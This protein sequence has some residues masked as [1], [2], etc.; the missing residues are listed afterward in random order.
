MTST[1]PEILVVGAGSAGAAVAAHLAEQ[2]RSVVLVD[3][4]PPEKAGAHWINAVPPWLFDEAGIA[5]PEPPECVRPARSHTSVITDAEGHVCAHIAEDP[6]LHVDMRLLTQRLQRRAMAAGAAFEHGEV[7][8]VGL[9]EGRI[10]TVTLRSVH[11][12]RVFLPR[13]TVDASGL[14]AVI[15]RRV[16]QLAIAYPGPRDTDI[17]QAAQHQ[18]RLADLDGAKAFLEAHGAEPGSNVTYTAVAGGYSILMV[19]VDETLDHVGVLSGTIPA[20]GV[21]DGGAVVDRFVADNPWIGARLSGG[22]APIP[23]G[24]PC[25]RLSAPGVALVGNAAGHVYAMHGSGVGLGLVAARLLAD[26]VAAAPDPG[27]PTVLQR[28]GA[29]FL[30]TYGGRLAASDL[31]RRF[32]QSLSPAEVSEFMRSGL[33]NGP[34]MLAGLKQRPIKA[35]PQAL[36][37]VLRGAKANPRLIAKLGPMA[38]R[39]L[40]AEKA[41]AFY[42]ETGNGVALQRFEHV[43]RTIRGF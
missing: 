28:Y 24:Q 18:Y 36:L 27:H 32:S 29:R 25:L 20:I 1:T 38:S 11:G 6:G 39:M 17:C 21:P 22:R 10:E 43:L 14:S 35:E 19:S 42:P 41:F 30:R 9:D 23:L 31:F 8:E 37:T 12:E 33:V 15:R 4:H 26:T 16:P 13:L 3:R 2:G 7:V 40:L 34:I 5:Q